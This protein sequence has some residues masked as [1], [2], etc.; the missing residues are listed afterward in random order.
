MPGSYCFT[1]M[2]AATCISSMSASVSD[3]RSQAVSAAG[4][5]NHH[6]AEVHPEGELAQKLQRLLIIHIQSSLTTLTFPVEERIC[7][8]GRMT[9]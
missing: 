9:R 7:K 1:R 2:L 4:H 8:L 3:S 6:L 5:G